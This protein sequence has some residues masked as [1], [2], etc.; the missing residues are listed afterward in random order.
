VSVSAEH[1][2]RPSQCNYSGGFIK[3]KEDYD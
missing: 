3:L 1:A 2:T